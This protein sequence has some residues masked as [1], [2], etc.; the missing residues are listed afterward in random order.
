MDLTT[1]PLVIAARAIIGPA[2]PA[3]AREAIINSTM[4]FLFIFIFIYFITLAIK[5]TSA[6]YK[7]FNS[8]YLKLSKALSVQ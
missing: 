1:I 6:S 8:N 7:K 2:D 3:T 4:K 5:I